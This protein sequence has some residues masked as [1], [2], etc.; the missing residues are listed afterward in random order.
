MPE[1]R[2]YTD[3]QLLTFLREMA[4][5][6]TRTITAREKLHLTEAADVIQALAARPTE[7]R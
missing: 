3:E 4:N 2:L 1:R 7:G 5:R 6:R